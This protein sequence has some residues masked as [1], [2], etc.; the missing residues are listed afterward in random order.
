MRLATK[1]AAGSAAVL[2]ATFSLA[3]A[4]ETLNGIKSK[5]FVQ[6][7]VNTGLPGFSNPDDE[8]KWQRDRHRHLP[9]C[10][11]CAVR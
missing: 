9:R 11:G 5:G 1:L 10:C 3:H 8:G 6:C 2:A 7:G 4:G